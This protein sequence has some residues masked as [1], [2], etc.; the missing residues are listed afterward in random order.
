[1]PT[2]YEAMNTGLLLYLPYRYAEERVF[3]A[4]AEQGHRV[5]AAQARVFQRIGSHGSRLVDLAE[6]TSL[7]KQSV[8]FL[9][10][11]LERAGLVSR[12]ADPSDARARLV[13]ITARGQEL[14]ADG[15]P[16]L[17][18]VEGEWRDLLG[19]EEYARLRQALVR[20]SAHSDRHTER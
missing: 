15:V 9:V 4:L 12:E 16:I 11:Q 1:M 18:E 19:E 13:T 17:A 3:T 14:I 20:L 8:G 7:T 2:D 5:T 6:A 10:D